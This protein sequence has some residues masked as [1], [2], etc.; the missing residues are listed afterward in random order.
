V[1]A[2]LLRAYFQKIRACGALR[3]LRAEAQRS[4]LRT[5][6]HPDTGRCFAGPWRFVPRPPPERFQF[7]SK[8]HELPIAQRQQQRATLPTEG[9]VCSKAFLNILDGVKACGWIQASQNP[10]NM[11][12]ST[13]FAILFSNTYGTPSAKNVPEVNIEV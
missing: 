3:G 8:V 11:A 2:P 10:L 13:P 4:R 6:R 9:T 12:I 5:R 7:S 1:G